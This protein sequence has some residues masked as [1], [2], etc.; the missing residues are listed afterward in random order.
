MK[1]V[2]IVTGGTSGMGLATAIEMGKSG[3]VLVGGRNEARIEKALDSLKA[4]GVEGY[5]HPCDISSLDSLKAFAEAARAIG[6]VGNVVNAAGVDFDMPVEKIVDIN[7]VGTINVLNTFF[8]LMSEGSSLVNYSSITGYMYQPFEEE[9]AV[10]DEPDDPDFAR[11]AYEQLVKHPN[12]MPGRLADAYPAYCGS[13]NF[14]M[15]YTRAN[16]ARFGAK[17]LRVFSVAPGSFMTPMLEGQKD[18]LDSIA[19]TTAFKRVGESEEMAHFIGCLLDPR[20]EYITG[21]DL[22]MD[23]GKLAMGMTKQLD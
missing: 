1:Q 18:Y 17:G 22:I 10:W 14:V 20:N 8:P 21:C 4:A 2:Q 13:K 3:P 7:M 5:G 16:T 23:G 12:P 11:K 19:A 15:H 9:I 6:E